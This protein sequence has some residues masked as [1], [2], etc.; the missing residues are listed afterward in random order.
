MEI[1]KAIHN[2]I[3]EIEA[4]VKE[5]FEEYI[6]LIGKKPAPML[7]NYKEIIEKNFVFVAIIEKNISG[8]VVICDTIENYMWLDTLSVFKKYQGQGIGKQLIIFTE[9]FIREKKKV[10]CRLRTNIKFENTVAIYRHLNYIEYQRILE[11]GYDR[12]Y[13]KK[14]LLKN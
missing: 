8:V 7:K 2:D 9:D 14:I 12:I 11:D 1:R 13:F 4:C 10:E 5:S 3:T 6:P